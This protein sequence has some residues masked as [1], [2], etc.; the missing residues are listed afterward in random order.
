MSNLEPMH[1]RCRGKKK[2]GPYASS[3]TNEKRKMGTSILR[4]L[5]TRG[6]KK[7]ERVTIGGTG[8]IHL[9]NGWWRKK[10]GK[11]RGGPIK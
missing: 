7:P 5:G 2:A 10:D 6:R 11:E 9:P 4:L 1:R 8:W 3:V